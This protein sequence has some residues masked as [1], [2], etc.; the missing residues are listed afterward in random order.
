[1]ESLGTDLAPAVLN[2]SAKLLLSIPISA[3]A[4]VSELELFRDSVNRDNCYV[5]F[6]YFGL[7][8][9]YSDFSLNII[10]FL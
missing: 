2:K 10:P 8:V 6:T 1:M 4:I 5:L 3:F 9:L 7:Q